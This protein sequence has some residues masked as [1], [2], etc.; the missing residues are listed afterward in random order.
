MIKKDNLFIVIHGG[1]IMSRDVRTNVT[2]FHMYKFLSSMA[3]WGPVIVVLLVQRGFSLFEIALGDVAYWIVIILCEVP[4][5]VIAD[6]YSRKYSLSVGLIFLSIALFVYSRIYT[7]AILI[8]CHVLWGIGSTFI[9]GADVALLYD[10]L[11]EC[12]REGEFEKIMGTATSISFISTGVSC[13]IGG[14]LASYDMKLPFVLTSLAYGAACLF[15]LCLWEPHVSDRPQTYLPHIRESASFVRKNRMLLWLILLFAGMFSTYTIISILRQPYMLALNIPLK[16][17]G[18]LYLISLLIKAVGAK[19]AY[20]IEPVLGEKKNLLLISILTPLAFLLAG[21]LRSYIGLFILMGSSFMVGYLYPVFDTYMN[22]Q[23]PS[24]RRA[25][26]FSFRG[27]ISTFFIAPLEPLFGKIADWYSV[28]F[29]HIL[30]G[31]VAIGSF[32][33]CMSFIFNEDGEKR[34]NEEKREG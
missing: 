27:M 19:L 17:F 14:F 3:L 11:Q 8:F 5:G 12:N 20:K 7:V 28:F 1:K 2:L 31:I 34:E 10:T 22:R 6:K 29:S 24:A 30:I 13:L 18:V 4:T 23:I 26:V 32:S 15:S 16:F 9:S 25:T 33:V 21:F